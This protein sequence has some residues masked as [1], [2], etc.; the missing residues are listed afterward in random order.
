MALRTPP[1]TAGALDGF[2]AG[3]RSTL[4]QLL[5]IPF[6][7]GQLLTLSADNA[8]VTV[9]I[10]HALGRK[11]KGWLLLGI[12]AASGTTASISLYERAGAESDANVLRLFQTA[13]AGADSTMLLWVF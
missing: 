12:H 4:R 3:A 5:S 9:E 8:A 1:Q 2:S 7:A 6:L 10:P 13:T 11:P